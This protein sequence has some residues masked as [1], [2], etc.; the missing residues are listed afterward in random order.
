MLLGYDQAFLPTLTQTQ[1]TQVNSQFSQLCGKDPA[2]RKQFLK[3]FLKEGEDVYS[4]L[5]SL[6]APLM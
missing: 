1:S 2:S 5:V 6:L 4:W 3:E